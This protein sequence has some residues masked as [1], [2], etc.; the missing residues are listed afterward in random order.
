MKLF[1]GVAVTCLGLSLL[2]SGCSDGKS[3]KS[4]KDLKLEDMT[5]RLNGTDFTLY[6]PISSVTKDTDWIM[7]ENENKKLASLDSERIHLSDKNNED[8]SVAINVY[9]PED[10]E[11]SYKDAKIYGVRYDSKYD[12]ENIE[13]ILPA[14]VE[15]GA[16]TDKIIS[17]FGTPY[18]MYSIMQDELNISYASSVEYDA[19]ETYN[20][21]VVGQRLQEVSMEGSEKKKEATKDTSFD[22]KTMMK[23][24]IVE[25]T[26]TEKG[27]S[28][29]KLFTDSFTVDGVKINKDTPI[30]AFTSQGLE[31]KDASARDGETSLT[32]ESGDKY[33]FAKFSGEVVDKGSDENKLLDMTI[34]MEDGQTIVFPDDM[35][36][37]KASES[38]VVSAFGFP[39]EI[40]RF[41]D[42]TGYTYREGDTSIE[43]SFENGKVYD[44]SFSIDTY[45]F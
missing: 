36:I 40:S 30:T 1:K 7:E 29:D 34:Y 2:L 21:T 5:I 8:I 27:P 3:A 24:D 25:I 42:A 9:N 16:S 33:F 35:D 15:M 11:I 45:L 17:A 14:G 28:F 38:D 18:E 43:I 31:V 22:T 26:S 32:L 39:T 4:A 6:Q 10:K 19:G 13:C 37:V 20:F 12:S 23:R 44:I 41:S